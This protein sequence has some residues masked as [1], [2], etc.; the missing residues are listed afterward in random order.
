[1]VL[2]LKDRC[3]GHSISVD[4]LKY[5]KELLIKKKAKSLLE[6]GTYKGWSLFSLYEIIRNQRGSVI[7]VDYIPQRY[8]SYAEGYSPDIDEI[9][10][11][12]AMMKRYKDNLNLIKENDL[13]NIQ[14]FNKG[15]D[16][17]FKENELNFDCIILHGCHE[18]NQVKRDMRNAIKYINSNGMIILYPI[19]EG[20][21]SNTKKVFNDASDADFDKEIHGGDKRIFGILKK[22]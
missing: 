1:M 10:S 16:Y 11:K 2:D 7:G 22:K 19:S 20:K 18:T 17:F 6:I 13:E 5:I 9:W 12:E 4:E 3:S 15:S 21:T 14:L 8:E